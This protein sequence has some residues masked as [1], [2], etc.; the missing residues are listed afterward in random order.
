ME[1]YRFI[2]EFCLDE[3]SG[4]YHFTLLHTS[5]IILPATS[6][7]IEICFDFVANTELLVSLRQNIGKVLV[8]NRNLTLLFQ[9]LIYDVL[10]TQSLIYGA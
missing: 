5:S 3:F 7:K 2:W 9:W 1:I 6:T 8:F 4:F 10:E